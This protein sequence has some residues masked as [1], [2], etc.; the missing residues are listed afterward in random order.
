M[1]CSTPG[2]PV[3]HCLLE[4][5]KFMSIEPLML[6]NH[7]ILCCP[8][9]LLSS[10]F[11]SIRVFSNESALGNEWQKYW[12]FGFSIRC[13]WG[14]EKESRMIPWLWIRA[15]GGACFWDG[16]N[17]EGTGLEAGMSR[18]P[19]RAQI[20]GRQPAGKNG[21]HTVDTQAWGPGETAGLGGG[22][23]LRTGWVTCGAW[24]LAGQ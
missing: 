13:G 10:I 12:S 7:L 17:G 14:R 18:V 20:P 23:S 21:S 5:L 11:A 24:R 1:D 6:S 3:L 4:L 22:M 15:N 9:L 2:F 19:L 16:K 8:L